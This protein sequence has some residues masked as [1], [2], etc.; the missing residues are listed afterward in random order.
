MA[1]FSFSDKLN[2]ITK[3]EGKEIVIIY[4]NNNPADDELAEIKKK[5]EKK[6]NR[7]IVLQFQKKDIEG[8]QLKTKDKII[9]LSLT[10]KLSNFKK[11]L[12]TK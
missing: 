9:D 1:N 5:L 7:Q 8:I 3:Q 6:L 4:A 11:I 2:K 12:L 10:N